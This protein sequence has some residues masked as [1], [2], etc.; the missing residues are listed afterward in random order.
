MSSKK[1]FLLG[2]MVGG[3]IGVAAVSVA[4]RSKKGKKS[5]NHLMKSV[6]EMGKAIASDKEEDLAEII[7]WTAEGIEL[8]KKIKKGS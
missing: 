2:A 1:D 6:G 7:E 4:K 8:W 5:A 3:M